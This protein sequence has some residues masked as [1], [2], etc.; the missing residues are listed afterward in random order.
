MGAESALLA[1]LI[2]AGSG[3]LG[4]VLSKCKC[5]YKRDPEG[6]CSPTFAFSDKSIQPDDHEIEIYHEQVGDEIP[7]LILTKKARA[8]S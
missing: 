1:T 4:V 3:L 7:V 2:T 5:L 6:N 8:E